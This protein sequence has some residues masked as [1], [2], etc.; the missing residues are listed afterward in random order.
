MTSARKIGRWLGRT[1]AAGVAASLAVGVIVIGTTPARAADAVE[2]SLQ[3][4]SMSVSGTKPKDK[5]TLKLTLSNTGTIPAYGVLAKIWRSQDPI[6]SRVDLANIAD[7]SVDTWGGWPN[8][9]GNYQLVTNS[10]TPFEPG[11]SRSFTLTGTL[12]QLGFTTKKVAYSLGVDVV[13]TADQSSNS[14]TVAQVRT[15]V[16]M[17]GKAAVPVTSLVLLSAPPTKLGANLFANEDLSAQLTGRLNSL[18]IAAS[19][20]RSN[21][22]ID[23]ALLDEVR[24]QADGYQV[25]HDGT[26]SEGT[27][28]QTAAAWLARFEKLDTTRGAR[29]L[30]AS[31]DTY[32]AQATNTEN[33]LA[34]SKTAT[35]TV[36]EVGSLPLIVVPTGN[37]VD[38]ANLAFLSSAGATAVTASNSAASAA[39]QSSRA[40]QAVLGASA[41]SVQ[42][43][44]GTSTTTQI[45][46]RQLLLA[47]TALCATNG[48]VRLLT[49]PAEV[50]LNSQAEPDWITT[51]SL[52]ALLNSDGGA[53]ASVK[54]TAPDHLGANSF[55][56]LRGLAAELK[57]YQDLVPD[58]TLAATPQAIYLRSV[59]QSWIG[60]EANQDEYAMALRNQ[61]GSDAVNDKVSLRAS[62]RFVMSGRTTEFPVT[63]TNELTEPVQVRVVVVTDNPQ[64]LTVPPSEL[65]TVQP[66]QSETVN[67]RPEATTNG[68]VTADAYL[69]DDAGRRVGEPVALTIEMTELGMVAWIIV[70]ISGVVLVIAT[71][72]RIRQ[73]R[74]RE[75][76]SA[77]NAE[78]PE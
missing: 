68:V 21:W 64:R 15:F 52:P 3:L 77:Q 33:L 8:L 10:T 5:V 44:V 45:Q 23:P 47:E 67:I 26:I 36:P 17:P 43:I 42:D 62:A 22:L 16:P 69:T 65:V 72:W 78:A 38:N 12:A 49:N 29:T 70:G 28:Q 6:R 9:P 32:G 75:S 4:T 48:Q 58:S 13:A 19:S 63:V 59:S 60:D 39:L 20:T 35:A 37:V 76:T 24:D 41:V 61:F 2:L 7:G 1:L 56:L 53:R 55:E 40:G 14:S 25:S 46:Q 18:L 54:D 50:A 30:F 34:W 73:V 66:G 74:R 71:W 51:R 11:A 31:P 57:A 27:G